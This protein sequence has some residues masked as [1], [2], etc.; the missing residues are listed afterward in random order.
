MKAIGHPV[1]GDDVYTSPR[2]ENFG[3]SG[4]CLHAKAIGFVHPRTGEHLYFESEL[5][6]YF[7]NVI[8]KIEAR[9]N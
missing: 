8:K 4:Q 1:V 9:Q 6:D 7:K 2:L 5:P 3:L